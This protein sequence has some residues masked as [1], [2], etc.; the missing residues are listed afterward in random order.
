MRKTPNRG[1]VGW[2]QG[3]CV[4]GCG[5]QGPLPHREEESV[6]KTTIETVHEAARRYLDRGRLI[7]PIEPRTKRPYHSEWNT[8][9]RWTD[10][11]FTE[12]D[13]RDGDQ[14]GVL[15]GVG[16][17]PIADVDCDSPEAIVAAHA[18][19][20][21][22][23]A[24]F[25]HPGCS[26]RRPAITKA[27]S[28]YLYIVE[29]NEK[30]SLTAQRL[31]GLLELRWC[32]KDDKATQS[33]V[34]PSLHDAGP[35]EWLGGRDD[36]TRI[37]AR[38]LWER[39]RLL[40]TATVLMHVA[41]PI[42]GGAN[43]YLLCA[44]GWLATLEV[45]Q[46]DAHQV[47]GL[48]AAWRDYDRVKTADIVERT[49]EKVAVGDRAKG[50]PRLKVEHVRPDQHGL[51][52]RIYTLFDETGSRKA[53]DALDA[54]YSIV[55]NRSDSIIVAHERAP[56]DG[57]LVMH[58]HEQF[59]RVLIKQRVQ[60]EGKWKPLADAWLR[61][62]QGTVYE[63]LVLLPHEVVRD[64]RGEPELVSMHDPEREYNAW[65]GYAV[66][67][68]LGDWSRLQGHLRGVWC[69]GH[70]EYYD[71]VLNWLAA[72]VQ[73]PGERGQVAVVVPGTK[74]CGKTIVVDYLMRIFGPAHAHRASGFPKRFNKQL[75]GKVLFNFN[76]AFWAGDHEAEAKLKEYITD[77]H[78]EYEGKFENPVYAKN[79]LHVVI[80][81]NA[82]WMVPSSFD[83]R[84]YTVFEARGTKVGDHDHFDALARELNGGG[85]A[86]L[87]YDLLRMRVDWRRA[88]TAL[89]TPAL[90]RQQE[91][92]MSL[93]Q[94]W[95]FEKLGRGV[96]ITGFDH[97]ALRRLKETHPELFDD[98][99]FELRGAV[100][101]T[102]EDEWPSEVE[103]ALLHAD[104]ARFVDLHGG[105]R[106]RKSTESE[107]GGFLKKVLPDAEQ[108]DIRRTV[109]GSLR[110]FWSVPSL[111]AC[112][113]V[114]CQSMKWETFDQGD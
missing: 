38:Y 42:G 15:L 6:S 10:E 1:V 23:D 13:L 18:L 54:K 70:A 75:F 114:W 46:S 112:K 98:G 47:L 91:R 103:K 32:T 111:D 49:Y 101:R 64:E 60:V 56:D 74:G 26:D 5:I 100:T 81:G 68:R 57:Q 30:S 29:N 4:R 59:R 8:K 93:I 16:P 7:V 25:G 95:W 55:V 45:D 62:P 58:S 82:E 79:M 97:T 110:R 94:R 11:R 51:L 63:R 78:F 102:I 87:L 96:L 89:W 107:L 53:F 80:T 77:G 12:R 9:K 90:R 113:R 28:H 109:D 24:I 66:E 37:E 86:A 14:I 40:A 22:T 19:L 31:T 108:R 88:R 92:S 104:Y 36:P 50:G 65:T 72:M 106:S 43:D 17:Q 20:P 85:P 33:L 34:P 52:D 3:G 67:P 71:W 69:G 84:R 83:E 73:R 27:A 35:R 105:T 41:P 48:V 61:R 99:L 44:A 39:W 76:E 21:P 2:E